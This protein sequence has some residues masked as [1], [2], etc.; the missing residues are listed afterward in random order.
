MAYC[1]HEDVQLNLQ[2]LELT[3]NSKPT[4]GEV[5]V[6][7]DQVSSDMNSRMEV[8]GISLPVSDEDKLDLL[9]KIAVD[10]VTARVFRS[11]NTEAALM[12]SKA[13]Q[14][15]YDKSMGNIEANPR[16]IDG[17]KNSA[18]PGYFITPPER[19]RKYNREGR[20]W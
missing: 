1:I 5:D 9:K 8:A 3:E 10:G 16:I 12:S 7:C 18:S 17:V 11:L 14:V 19:K 13:Y 15:E 4:I 6:F 2:Y 20:N